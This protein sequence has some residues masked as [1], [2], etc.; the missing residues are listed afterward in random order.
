MKKR[1]AIISVTLALILPAY[2]QKREEK[3]KVHADFQFGSY[4]T[5]REA[6]QLMSNQQSILVTVGYAEGWDFD[7][8]SKNFKI[9]VSDLSNQSDTLEDE[10]LVDRRDEYGMRPAMPVI[11][12]R[13][14]DRVKD[15]VQRHTQE[16]T[17]VL[18]GLWPEID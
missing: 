4:P 6:A 15:G 17:K 9:S 2:A 10:R 13:D 8:L 3:P 18:G 16:F 11:R 1:L 12:E 7:K 5:S 14:W